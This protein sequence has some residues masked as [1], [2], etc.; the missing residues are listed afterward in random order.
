MLTKKTRQLLR[1]CLVLFLL[2]FSTVYTL[3]KAFSVNIGKHVSFGTCL[4]INYYLSSF[5]PNAM[6]ISWFLLFAFVFPTVL[7]A[8]YTAGIISASNQ[9]YALPSF[10]TATSLIPKL[11]QRNRGAVIGIQRGRYTSFE[12]GGEAH[13]RKLSIKKAHI[14]GATA[15]MEYNPFNNVIG[16]KAGLWMK[17]GRVNLTYGGNLVY[18][19]DFKGKSRYGAGPVIGFRLA[20]FHLTNGYNF[21]AGNKELTKVNTLYISLRYF[22]PLDNKFTWDRK[23]K[24]RKQK[25]KAKK[26]RQREKE[27]DGKKKLFPF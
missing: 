7:H 12:L 26:K 9:T 19:N 18:Y 3:S 20:G 4:F 14:T 17:R 1:G 11:N 2:F 16:Y 27:K 23:D 5:I 24:D 8:Q 10:S 21:L 15:T 13:W 6:K 25:D 22:F